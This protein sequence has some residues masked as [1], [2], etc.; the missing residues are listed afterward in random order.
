MHGQEPQRELAEVNCDVGTA[1][2][3]KGSECRVVTQE[4]YV[5]VFGINEPGILGPVVC[6]DM[7]VVTSRIENAG[8]SRYT[9]DLL[10]GDDVCVEQ[11]RITRQT[12]VVLGSAR[13]RAAQ[14][15]RRKPLEIP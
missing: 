10:H 13:H 1:A 3:T 2:Q 14:V 12:C 15:G 4:L 6:G 5:Q 8:Q 9:F 7:K 11:R